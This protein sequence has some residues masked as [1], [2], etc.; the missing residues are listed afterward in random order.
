MIKPHTD[1]AGMAPS[2][3]GPNTDVV[4]VEVR[5]G[6]V[7]HLVAIQVADRYGERLAAGAILRAE[8]RRFATHFGM[9]P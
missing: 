5:H 2:H 4:A 7:G 6:Q 8:E 3:S 9:H 1:V